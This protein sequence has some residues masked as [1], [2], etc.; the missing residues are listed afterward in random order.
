MCRGSVVLV[1]ERAVA[2]VA[3]ENDEGWAALGLVEDVDRALDALDVV[4]I[5]DPQDIPAV[6]EEAGRDILGERDVGLAV[7]RDAIVVVDPAQVIERQMA[8]ERSGLRGDALHHVAVAAHRIDVVAEDLEAVPIV[9]RLAEPRLGDGHA[10]AVGDALAERPAGG[11][12][13]GHPVIFGM[14]RRLAAELAEVADIVERHRRLAEPLVVGIDGARAGEM[15]QRPQQHGRM[16]VREH[17]AIAVWPDRILRIE[18]HDPVPQG[19]DQ[20]RQ[21]HR[22]AGM[23]GV[24]LLHGIDRQGANAI[25]RKLVELGVGHR[26]RLHLGTGH[27][28]HVMPPF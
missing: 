19:V 7:D 2:D 4:G 12:D 25:D 5:A 16:A 3:V 22:R 10:D 14:A 9:A 28:T 21:R 18:A 13:A 20:R 6:A 11:L 24:R 17:E 27:R 26:L 23:A 8:G 1:G 15:E